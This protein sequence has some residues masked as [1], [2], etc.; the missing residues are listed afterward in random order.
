MPTK[1]HDELMKALMINDQGIIGFI[2]QDEYAKS[3]GEGQIVAETSCINAD[4]INLIEASLL[5]YRAVFLSYQSMEKAIAVLQFYPEAEE[6][7]KAMTLTQNMLLLAQRVALEG[8]S[9]VAKS[10]GATIQ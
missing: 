2:D 9:E 7:I 8:S 10:I 6:A 3:V 5:L 4:F 1:T